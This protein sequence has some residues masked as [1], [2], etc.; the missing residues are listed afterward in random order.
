MAEA[1]KPRALEASSLFIS[2]SMLSF[3]HDNALASQLSQVSAHSPE[4]RRK[5]GEHEER[6]VNNEERERELSFFFHSLFTLV[7]LSLSPPFSLSSFQL[8]SKQKKHRF[9]SAMQKKIN[10]FL[11]ARVARGAATAAASAVAV[12]VAAVVAAFGF[13]PAAV[14][15]GVAPPLFVLA[16]MA[17][18]AVVVE[19]GGRSEAEARA[20]AAT[21]AAAAAAARGGDGAGTA[22]A[23]GAA[24]TDAAARGEEDPALA[25][26]P[27]APAAAAVLSS[28]S[29]NRSASAA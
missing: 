16:A 8:Q 18:A 26:A 20:R 13:F 17:T 9:E 28:S 6:I 14:A 3:N 29:L 1:Q 11:L 10:H 5:E 4:D 21:G 22:A 7:F 2:T 24:A 19:E 12:A 27:A 25:A 23:T 15:F